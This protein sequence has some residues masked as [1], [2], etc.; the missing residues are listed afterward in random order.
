M[1]TL[2][3]QEIQE[4]RTELWNAIATL[5]TPKL[6]QLAGMANFYAYCIARHYAAAD[7][8]D[9]NLIVDN[10]KF[11]NLM[12]LSTAGELTITGTVLYLSSY[13]QEHWQGAYF[14]P[15]SIRR[16]REFMRDE[17]KLFD[18]IPQ[19]SGTTTAPPEL[20]A[21]D[22][23]RLLLAYEAAEWELHLRSHIP[24]GYETE[25]RKELECYLPGHLGLNMVLLFNHCFDGVAAFRRKEV[26][27]V[28]KP[29]C[30]DTVWNGETSK[31]VPFL[32][33][34]TWQ[35]LLGGCVKRVKMAWNSLTGQ[36]ERCFDSMAEY[37]E[38]LEQLEVKINPE[39]APW[40]AIAKQ[41]EQW[42]AAY[43]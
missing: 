13:L 42:E 4:S 32:D 43:A 33:W 18:F 1:L 34:K 35:E 26:E 39:E 37:R 30:L 25:S 29:K 9:G 2:T 15:R 14:S 38:H 40:D 24:D 5:P 20:K 22:F 27:V 31:P 10:A 8:V 19:V 12:A 3:I 21:I 16:C 28:V 6:L 17:L 36:F 7:K 23:P 41:M 11:E